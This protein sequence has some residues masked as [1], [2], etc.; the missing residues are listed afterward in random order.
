MDLEGSARGINGTLSWHLPEVAEKTYGKY[1]WI[2]VV[3]DTW[4]NTATPLYVFVA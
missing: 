1:M 3:T 2:V 4:I